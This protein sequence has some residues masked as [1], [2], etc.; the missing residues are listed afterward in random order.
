MID[1]WNDPPTAE[2]A[3][4]LAGLGAVK[5]LHVFPDG[6]QEAR[7]IAAAPSCSGES[8][9]GILETY[10][11]KSIPFGWVTWDRPEDPVHDLLV[12]EIVRLKL[13]SAPGA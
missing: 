4:A 7:I 12:D 13:A 10:Q 1:P 8:W 2:T 3:C 6:D 9:I 11:R 5:V